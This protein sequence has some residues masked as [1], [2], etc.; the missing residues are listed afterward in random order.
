MQANL[1]LIFA[2]EITDLA[3]F[4]V[5]RNKTNCSYRFGVGEREEDGKARRK[6]FKSLLENSIV[7]NKGSINFP[8]YRVLYFAVP[9][10][11][12]SVPQ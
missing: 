6:A 4:G 10:F 3:S 12:G 5:N 7:S 9:G 1:K 11:V 8:I 2:A